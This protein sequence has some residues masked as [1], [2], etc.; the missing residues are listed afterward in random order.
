MSKAESRVA[1]LVRDAIA[2]LRL[3]LLDLTNRNRLLNFKFP[4]TSRKFIRIIDSLPDALFARLTDDAANNGRLYFA[5]LPEP[6]APAA[7]AEPTPAQLE[8]TPSD[9]PA[10][11]ASVRPTSAQSG[12]RSRRQDDSSASVDPV[13]WA[14]RHD[15]DPSFDL[16]V[17][18]AEQG[19]GNH[20]SSRLQT[21][22]F[23]EPFERTLS[24]IREDANLAQQEL[25]L[26]TLFAAFGYLEWYESSSSEE[27]NYAPLFL[28]PVEIGRELVRSEY[29]YFIECGENSD[30]MINIS[31]RERLKRD[32]SLVLPELDEEDTPESYLKRV[33]IAIRDQTR[34]RIKRFVVIGH[35]S[36]ARL[37][38]YQDLA[39][40]AWPAA[41]LETNLL[42]NTLLAGAAEGSADAYATE[43]D[44]DEESIERLVPVCVTDADSSQFSALV[45]AMQG[46]NFA[47][48]GP[49]GT[50]KSQTITNLI[51]AALAANKRVLFVA[52]KQPALE[53][54][55]NRLVAAGLGPYLLELHS[56]K[57]QKRRVL[58]SLKSRLEI[59]KQRANILLPHTL[60]ELRQ[61][62]A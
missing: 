46:R 9:G 39:A 51:A 36:F 54:V 38:M 43:F 20:G 59:R 4:E 55:A 32:F 2:R 19:N 57:V 5:S 23:P 15:I 29:R 1:K 13:E 34:W 53:V 49:P 42:L 47:L 12:W 41:P 44:V 28:L 26:S 7:T 37:V 62:R 24:A 8:L 40:E 58:E 3:K 25:G 11:A 21:L 60:L 14:R 56:T 30:P 50:G 18:G 52:E 22:L 48:K 17:A 61:T 45:D 10:A 35:F 27:A 16:P 6:P 31:L 33:K